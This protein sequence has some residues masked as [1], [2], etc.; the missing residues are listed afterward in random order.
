M[1]IINLEENKKAYFSSDNHLGLPGKVNSLKREKIFVKLQTKKKSE[2]QAQ[3]ESTTRT[4]KDAQEKTSALVI[5][6]ERM[7]ERARRNLEDAVSHHQRMLRDKTDE[8]E[9]AESRSRELEARLASM[10]SE[11]QDME[12]NYLKMASDLENALRVKQTAEEKAR[13]TSKQLSQ[14]LE[15]EEIKLKE[16]TESKLENER[17][18]RQVERM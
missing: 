17:L 14:I 10:I 6:Q 15:K 7:A 3:K 18:K 11:Q 13:V 16:L 8:A 4:H 12:D 1:E 2:S 9:R 5:A